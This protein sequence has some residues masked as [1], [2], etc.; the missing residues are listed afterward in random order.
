MA[1]ASVTEHIATDHPMGRL[2]LHMMG[3]MA[4]WERETI[5]ERARAGMQQRMSQ[6]AWVGGPVPAGCQVVVGPDGLRRLAEHPEEGPIVRDIW[7]RV[8]QGATLMDI[9]RYLTA[10]KVT[11]PRKLGWRKQTVHSLMR[12]ERLIGILTDEA[13]FQAAAARLKTRFRK[14]DVHR[15]S[16]ASRIYPLQHLARCATCGAPMCGVPMLSKGNTYAYYRGTAKPKGLCRAKD[17][18]GEAWERAAMEGLRVLVER[19]G[20]LEARLQAD[21]AAADGQGRTLAAERDAILAQRAEVEARMNKLLDLVEQGQAPGASVRGRLAAMQA[22]ADALER[23]ADAMAGQIAASAM[24]RHGVGIMLD[25]LTR[26]LDALSADLEVQ[27][28]A[29]HTFCRSIRMGVHDGVP[30][31]EFAVFLPALW[32]VCQRLPASDAVSSLAGLVVGPPGFEP[33]QR[34][35]KSLVLPLHHGPVVA[36]ACRARW[37]GKAVRGRRGAC[38]RQGPCRRPSCRPWRRRTWR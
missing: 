29:L 15:V 20:P 10:A 8:A 38:R 24:E 6:G 25:E 33:R 13:T 1:L 28:R 11:P 18:P 26:H 35:S 32:G 16:T 14:V 23:R 27:R 31:L 36:A 9:A 19:G 22:E 17:L 30:V 37:P 7:P 21:A 5:A 3:S 12:Q 2:M 34:E 4:Q